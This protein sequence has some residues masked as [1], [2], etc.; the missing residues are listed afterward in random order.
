MNPHLITSASPAVRSSA[1]S[2]SE[3]VQV[4]EH[5]AGGWNAPTRFL[6]AAT[7][8]PVLPPTDA[9]TMPSSDVDTGTQRTPRSQHAAT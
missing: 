5:P 3:R 1:G 7:F 2:V 8:T 6:P 9:S 4:A